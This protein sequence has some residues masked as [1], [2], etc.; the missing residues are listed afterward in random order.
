LEPEILLV[1]EVLAVGDAEFQRRSLGKMS[2]VAKGGRTVLFVSHNLGAIRRLCSH[3]FLLESGKLAFDGHVDEALTAYER[4]YG[5]LSRLVASTNFHGP[6][7]GQVRLD[8]ITCKQSGSI[9]SVL[10]S[11]RKFE[12]EVG[13]FALRP[14]SGLELKLY[15]CRDGL[16]IASC[17]DTPD[18]APLH[19]GHFISRFE[20]PGDVFR[21]GMYTVAIGLLESTGRWGWCADVAALD[22]SENLGAR[23]GDRSGGVI[24]IPYSAQRIQQNSMSEN[25]PSIMMTK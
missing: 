15:I 13:A 2:D 4:I 20:F 14:F 21:P 24:V 17:V 16:H 7:A 23:S 10:N 12:I 6:L 11:L 25:R 9:I 8:Q 5:S 22:F 19:A 18:Q 3:A 1:D